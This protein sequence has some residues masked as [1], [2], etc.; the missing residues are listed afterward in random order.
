MLV[1]FN[2]E[3]VDTLN[4]QSCGAKEITSKKNNIIIVKPENDTLGFVGK[5]IK[6]NTNTLNKL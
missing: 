4:N 3:I 2:K 5:P 6:I 1:Q